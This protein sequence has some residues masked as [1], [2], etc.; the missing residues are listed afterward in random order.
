M[1]ASVRLRHCVIAISF[2]M[3]FATSCRQRA[4]SSN[5]MRLRQ[6]Y[7]PFRANFRLSFFNPPILDRLWD[8]TTQSL[9]YG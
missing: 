2:S 7:R 3:S 9:S 8:R 5:R 4:S 6:A 1:A